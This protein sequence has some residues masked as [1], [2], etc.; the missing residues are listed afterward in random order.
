MDILNVAS[1]HNTNINH[2]YDPYH[3]KMDGEKKKYILA[4]QWN[5]GMVI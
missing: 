2:P 5:S 4:S 1:V 3:W